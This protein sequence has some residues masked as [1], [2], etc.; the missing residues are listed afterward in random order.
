MTLVTGL[1]HIFWARM[2]QELVF[3]PVS[4]CDWF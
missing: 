2:C 1:V 4:L 3:D